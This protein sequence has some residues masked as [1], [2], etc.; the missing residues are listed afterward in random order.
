MTDK[1]VK[2]KCDNGHARQDLDPEDSRCPFCESLNVEMRSSMSWSV[3]FEEVTRPPRTL[4]CGGCHRVFE[5]GDATIEKR[6]P[7][8]ITHV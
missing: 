8:V 5:D 6:E 7:L 2:S 3:G 4:T 1:F